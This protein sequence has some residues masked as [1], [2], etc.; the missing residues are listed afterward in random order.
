[1]QQGTFAEQLLT[2]PGWGQQLLRQSQLVRSWT[3]M[4]ERRWLQMAGRVYPVM[5]YLR[6]I[7]RHPTGECPWCGAGVIETL[8][9]F[10]SECAQ[11]ELNRT[12]AHHAIARATVAAL[13]DM[14][15]PKWQFF[16]ETSLEELPV[17]F[18]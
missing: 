12:A 2:T 3:E 15:L 17:K 11:F 13:K 7:D 9:H 6:R 16:Y 18:T 1:M 4:E 5:S 14:H 10:Q 8:C